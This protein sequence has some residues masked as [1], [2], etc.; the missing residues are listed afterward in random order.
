LRYESLAA[1]IACGD[2]GQQI[3]AAALAGEVV[4]P[5]HKCDF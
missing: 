1:D 4:V 3:D 2:T 5:R